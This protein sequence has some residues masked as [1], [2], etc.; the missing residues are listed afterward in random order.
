MSNSSPRSSVS[1]SLIVL[2][3]FDGDNLSDAETVRDKLDDFNHPRA[4][5]R[6][7]VNALQGS[8]IVAKYQT[9]AAKDLSVYHKVHSTG[10]LEFLDSAW[11]RWDALGTEGQD[12][13]GCM[14]PSIST[15]NN[16][17]KSPPLI[18]INTPLA[19]VN[20]Q[21]PSAH[22][23]GAMGYYCTD[24]CTPIF[25]GIHHELLLDAG[26]VEHTLREV[27]AAKNNII[28]ALPTHPGHHAAHDSFGGYCY[29]NHAAALAQGLRGEFFKVAILDIDYHAGNG[30]AE[31]FA[32]DAQ[33]LVVSIHCDPNMEYP[34]HNGYANETG[35]GP[36]TGATLNL[37]L[38]AK[39]AWPEY[40]KALETGLAKIREFEAQ[41]VVISLGLDTYDQDPC[42]IRRAGFGL[43]DHDYV[44]MG[45]TIAHGL[46][47]NVSN[48]LARL[49][50]IFTQEGGYRMDK[51]GQ[52][53]ADV[54]LSCCEERS[55]HMKGSGS[56]PRH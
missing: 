26:L 19:R 24:Q 49:P 11:K 47:M 1:C 27:N 45:R 44:E 38:P 31:I 10:L 6:L 42:A 15:A 35:V 4:R 54:V 39:T 2:T 48:G 16:N 9:K 21:Q 53:A 8:N 40:K 25:D 22:V 52:A 51:I 7:I 5:R 29:L 23:M 32:S 12:P 20:N 50:I 34:F 36:G 30:T 41:A 3:P 46:K 33:V 37:P 17:S 28:Y 14:A 56:S 18:P 55:L 13:S 43:K